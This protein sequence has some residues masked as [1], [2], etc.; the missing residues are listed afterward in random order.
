MIGAA[1]LL[2]ACASPGGFGESN[3]ALCDELRKDLPTYS[4]SDTPET[5]EAGADFI[6]LFNGLC[7]F[8][9]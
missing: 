6:D 1:M 4:A 8:S 9:R 5:L 3:R 7:G 2:T